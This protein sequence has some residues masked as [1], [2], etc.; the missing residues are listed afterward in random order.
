MTIDTGVFIS[1]VSVLV[2]L[3]LAVLAV[4]IQNVRALGDTASED[5]VAEVEDQTQYAHTRLTQ[6]LRED[7]QQDAETAE[8]AD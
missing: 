2:G 3:D 6:H 8:V 7:H 5:D 4:S 1:G